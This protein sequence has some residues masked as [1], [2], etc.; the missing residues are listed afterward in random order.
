MK[1]LHLGKFYPPARGGMETIL[2]LVCDHTSPHVR[3]RVL[4]ANDCRSTVDEN[5]AGT[6]VVRVAALCRI[7][8]VSICPTMPARLLT[9]DADIVV[10]HEPN[11]MG[12]LAYYLARP[13][14]RL[15]VWFHS[16]VIRPGWL[17]RFFYRPFFEF[18][19][20]R[21]STIVV[22]SPTLAASAP[23][24]RNWQSKCVV[25]PYGIDPET[26]RQRDAALQRATEIRQ[27][28]SRPL[29]LF[30]GRL[31][32]Y[33][34]VD[35]LLQAMC[36]TPAIAVIVGEGPERRR[37]Q[38]KA[39]ELGLNDQVKLLGEV[40][41]DELAALYH[42]CDV[43]VLPS[44][45]R[46]EAFGVVQVEAMA[47]GKP[48][49]CSD[50][51]TGVAWVNR[52]GET[53]L[54]VPPGDASALHQAIQ[55]LLTDSSLRT[56]MGGNAAE[57]AK[58]MFSTTCMIDA[59]LD[60]YRR[61]AA[62]PLEFAWPS[63]GKR[64]LDVLLA[65]TGLIASAP[66]WI[67]LSALIKL[68]DGGPVFFPQERIGLG[69]RRFMALKF[70][71]MVADAEDGV[72]AIQSRQ[73]DPRV[74]RIGR[75]MRATAMDELPQLWNIVRGDMSFVGPRALRPGEIEVNG[76]GSIERLEDVP[77]FDSRCAVRPGLTGIAQI[78]APRDIVR[79]RKFRYDRFYIRRQSLWL[80]VRL[81]LLSFWISFRGTWE[82]R[83]KKY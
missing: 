25:I 22:A 62:E 2:Q 79:R 50:L 18:A 46:Q 16:E 3:N 59:T 6:D 24:L 10:I 26:P 53:G 80:D 52:A 34:G 21:A 40:R 83:G 33:K 13:A 41:S 65:G 4:V 81:I 27:A 44:V 11:P 45:T 37:L 68:E 66:V 29:V 49:I 60:L 28:L 72:G 15:I 19:L 71:S 69:G 76:R 56:E 17:Y 35:V 5:R 55:R 74:T 73:N 63:A 12:L 23:Q 77:G 20:S 48:V 1:I 9:E 31:V 7:G 67:V 54:V 58:T 38:Q 39:E 78:Y 51:G 8:S 42:A 14:G 75:L 36:G 82:A 57:R 30:V 70:R 47:R 61:T 32:P 64:A 43:L